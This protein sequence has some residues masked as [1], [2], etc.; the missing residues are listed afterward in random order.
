MNKTSYKIHTFGCKVNTYDTG[1]LERRLEKA[2]FCPSSS[3]P[4]K[5]PGLVRNNQRAN[6]QPDVHILNTCAVTA[7]ATKEAQRKIR[8]I[9][10][11]NPFSL[12]V[13]TG[14]AAQVD[15]DQL[16]Q[17]RGVDLIVANSHKGH[18]EELI[19]RLQKGQLQE[20]VFKSNIFKKLDLEE[21]GGV[22]T[23]HTRA[24][25]KIQ[26]GCNSFCTYCV[27][28]F[29]RGK[30]RSLRVDSL[31]ARVNSLVSEGVSEVVLVGVHI[32]DYQDERYGDELGPAS[33]M[34]Q[35]LHRTK[36]GRIRLS[37]LEPVEV[38]DRLLDL[39]QEERIC[40]H[41]HMSIQSA[42]TKTLTDMKRQYDST[43]VEQVFETIAQRVP[44][45]F[46]GMDVIAGFPG[47]S[48]QDFWETHDRLRNLPWTKMHVFPYS[49][50]PGTYA[51]RIPE[52][53]SP[54]V[55]ADRARR[56]RELSE[57]RYVKM[58]LQQVGQ[59]K[60]V[61]TLKSDGGIL[62]GLSRDYW[63]VQLTDRDLRS[64]GGGGP[65]LNREGEI[66]H[67]S[68]GMEIPVKIQ[69][70]DI[71]GADRSE[72]SLMGTPVFTKEFKPSP[73]S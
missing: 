1:L 34:E 6:I 54:M 14:C 58:A 19:D 41:F 16:A 73:R 17:L 60:R 28:P 62:R 3:V 36:I 69:G 68:S 31:V 55:I 7:E 18:L 23:H 40:P 52:K 20:R 10:A 59:I 65:A 61:L 30:S 24:F 13:V 22:E 38:S 39:F 44:Q 27:I 48:D 66:R 71:S 5:T 11:Q 47:E 49:E 37:S 43:A 12:V 32:G 67:I 15:T 63:P 46:V 42:C 2:G 33:L 57:E 35:L 53:N 45:A 29:A 9:K 25:L 56:L 26:D 64:D 72:R 8:R 70:F 50:R 4:A 51:Q 21:G